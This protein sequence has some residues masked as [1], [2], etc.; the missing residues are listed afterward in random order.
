MQ[1]TTST[2]RPPDSDTGFCSNGSHPPRLAFTLFPRHIDFKRLFFSLKVCVAMCPLQ[3]T[4][5]KVQDIRYTLRD[6]RCNV[7]VTRCSSQGIHYRVYVTKYLLHGTRRM[8]ILQ[9]T[10]GTNYNNTLQGAHYTVHVTSC[11]LQ[12]TC[13]KVRVTF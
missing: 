4:C 9:G 11:M 10:Q 7:Y 5:Y 12:G 3:G 6:I 1:S 8:V 2:I 13:Y